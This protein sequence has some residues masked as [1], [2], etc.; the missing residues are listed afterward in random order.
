MG[1]YEPQEVTLSVQ[2]R[3]LKGMRFITQPRTAESGAEPP[4]DEKSDP[5]DLEFSEATKLAMRQSTLALDLSPEGG[6]KVVILQYSHLGT[7]EAIDDSEVIE[8]LAHFK[9]GAGD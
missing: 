1:R 4:L 7:L 3:E 6:T 2:G 9:L 8:F 5:R